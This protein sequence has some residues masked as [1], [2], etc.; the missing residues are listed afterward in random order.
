MQTPIYTE[1]GFEKL[2]NFVNENSNEKFLFFVDENTHEYC[3]PLLLAKLPE[4]EDI[5][6]IEI[7]A[8]EEFKSIEIA[9]QVWLSLGELNTDRNAIIFN[10]GGGVITDFGGF[11]ASTYKR[12]IRFVNI[13]TTLLAMVDASVGAKTG[14]NLEHFKN[15]IGTFYAP[16]MVVISSDFLLTLPETEIRSGFAEMLKHGLIQDIK[17]W[18]DLKKIDNLNPENIANFITQSI[19]IKKSIVEKDPTERG[20]RKILNAGHTL[21]HALESFY[22]FNDQEITHGEAVV[23]GLILENYISVNRN[24]LTWDE[25]YEILKVCEKFYPKLILPDSEQILPIL[26]YDKKNVGTEINA[27]L[28]NK[29]GECSPISSSI[30]KKEIQDAIDFYNLNYNEN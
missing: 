4:I 24:Q 23:A 16:E 6:I 9:I 5:E 15:Q 12:G 7:P 8:G 26:L 17:Y 10:C 20:L 13:P 19:E 14:I 18:K 3:L 28:L 30:F 1:N 27:N 21:G 2:S 25:F 29:I 22:L 11:V